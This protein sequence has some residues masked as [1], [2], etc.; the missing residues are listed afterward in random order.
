MTE[1]L[2]NGSKEKAL[3]PWAKKQYGPLLGDGGFTSELLPPP[4]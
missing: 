4:W 2:N 1:V 3:V